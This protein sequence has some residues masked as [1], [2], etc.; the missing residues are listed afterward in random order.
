MYSKY[1]LYRTESGFSLVELSIVLV[2]LG[3][4][5]G[6]IL[7][8]KSLI[9]ASQLRGVIAERES[10]V[11]ATKAFRD[12]YF[13]LPGDITNATQFWGAQ[14]V[15]GPP[16]TC[17]SGNMVDKL[18]CDGDGDGMVEDNT[19]PDF[20]TTFR[21]ESYYFFQ[22]LV[23]AELIQ[24]TPPLLWMYSK[25]KQAT[26]YVYFVQS[27]VFPRFN[28]PYGNV[29][30]FNANNRIWSDE[31][32]NID[33]KIDDGLPTKGKMVSNTFCTDTSDINNLNA[34][35]QLST[36]TYIGCGFFLREQF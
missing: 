24:A 31:V 23:N 12:K 33:A 4:M 29:L 13:G 15:P 2:V 28:I 36:P 1:K 26:W 8:G 34:A 14:T 32:W 3:L 9:R 16:W 17:A 6:G 5:V 25:L 7:A 11:V 19:A 30:M 10:I 18:T 27:A 20:F 22:Q 35:Y 21:S